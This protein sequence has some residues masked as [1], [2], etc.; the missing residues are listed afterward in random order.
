MKS[1]NVS[2]TEPARADL[3]AAR[4]SRLL[5]AGTSSWPMQSER[6]LSA[7]D[8]YT[9]VANARAY[10]AKNEDRLIYCW[11]D[12]ALLAICIVWCVYVIYALSA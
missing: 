12:V 7:E 8:R 4:R 2:E 6:D 11:G 3:P 10:L 9:A 1:Y 5:P